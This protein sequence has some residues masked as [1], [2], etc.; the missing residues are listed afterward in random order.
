MIISAKAKHFKDRTWK[1]VI[2]FQK[3]YNLLL[4]IY[5]FLLSLYLKPYFKLVRWNYKS[6]VIRLRK[7]DK[8]NVAFFV[9]HSDVWKYDML[10]RLMENHPR[11]EPIIFVCPVV[12]F[13][14]GNMLEQMGK[15]YDMFSK[16]GYNVVKTYNKMMILILIS[17][18]ICNGYYFY[19]NPYQG[20][21]MDQ[22]FITKFL[23][24]LTCYVPYSFMIL[25]HRWAY[26]HLF[27][28]L[29][30]RLFYPNDMYNDYAKKFSSTKCKNVS[31]TG[32]PMADVFMNPLIKADPWKIKDKKIKR[33]I[34][35]PHHTIS[36]IGDFNFQV[37]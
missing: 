30:W 33:I 34:W 6:V 28:N 21:I 7:K 19:T 37:L 23:N 20:L 32:Y 1:K 24:T 25:R 15:T 18:G 27:Y 12:N 8:L 4:V 13:G 3:I 36:T 10:Y 35:A 31:I 16:L 11:F 17:K 9:L 22:Y 29:A 5:N 26:D 14:R 2:G